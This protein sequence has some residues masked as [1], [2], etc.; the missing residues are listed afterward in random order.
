MFEN[1]DFLRETLSE[2]IVVFARGTIIINGVEIS[3][4]E[5]ER[6]REDSARRLWKLFTERQKEREHLRAL[7]SAEAE[8][9]EALKKTSNTKNKTKK[10]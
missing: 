9:R 5:K 1:E 7:E 8:K 6:L 3:E 2:N 4:K 10:T